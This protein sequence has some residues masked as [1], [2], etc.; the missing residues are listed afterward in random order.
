MFGSNILCT[1]GNLYLIAVFARIVV[2]WFPVQPGSG[3]AS[4]VS[5]LYA[6]TEPVLGPLRRAVPAMRMGG[7]GLDLSPIIVVLLL[8]LLVLPILCGL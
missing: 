4:V 3:F 6:I 8:Q 7:M 2:S 1:I 5:F